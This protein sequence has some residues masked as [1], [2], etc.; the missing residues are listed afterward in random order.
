MPFTDVWDVTTPADSQL[1]NLLGQDIR[2]L[3]L[4]IQQRMGA[5]SGTLATRWNPATDAQPTNWTGVLYFTT[6]TNQVFQWNGAAWVDVTVLIAS[7]PAL[8]T[9]QTIINQTVSSGTV[10][11]LTATLD[12]LYRMTM[13]GVVTQVGTG[14]TLSMTAGWNNGLLA[15]TAS[16]IATSLT[17]LGGETVLTS[18][19]YVPPGQNMTYAFN[20]NAPTGTPKYSGRVRLEYLGV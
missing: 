13:D 15:Q 4:D 11:L 19:M 12:G 17:V 14:G 7:L 20:L 1:A 9:K 5:M 16:S 3:K 6:D 18:V 10:V 2:N 8:L